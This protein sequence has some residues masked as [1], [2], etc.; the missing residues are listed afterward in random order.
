[1]TPAIFYL[2]LCGVVTICCH[3]AH[4]GILEH[5]MVPL[6]HGDTWPGYLEDSQTS[7]ASGHF[8]NLQ[9]PGLSKT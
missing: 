8:K 7:H 4:H 2:G 5:D 1:M 6:G 9:D 3:E